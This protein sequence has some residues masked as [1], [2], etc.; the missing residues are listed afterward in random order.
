MLNRTLLAAM[1]LLGYSLAAA[2]QTEIKHV[3]VA[4]ASA[5][6]GHEMF[7]NYCASCH[8]TD[9]K[10][11]G[12]AAVALKVPPADLSVLSK[13]NGGKFPSAHLATVLRDGVESKA[14]GV[15]EMP[16]W[17]PILRQTSHGQAGEVEL[18]IANLTKYVESLQVK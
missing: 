7:V 13:N 8:G 5:S 16:V 12:P 1:L 9:G 17:G 2:A 11:S 18:R 3:P 10:G 6:S 15:K 4:R 14:H